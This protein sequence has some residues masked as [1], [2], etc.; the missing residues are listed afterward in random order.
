MAII[1]GIP[2]FQ[3][4]PYKWKFQWEMFHCHGWLPESMHEWDGGANC[5]RLAKARKN[6]WVPRSIKSLIL[7]WVVEGANVWA[8]I[9]TNYQIDNQ[10]GGD[11]TQ[12]QKKTTLKRTKPSILKA[13][14]TTPPQSWNN[15]PLG[16]KHCTTILVF[17]WQLAPVVQKVQ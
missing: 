6:L 9:V 8:T 11:S 7:V 16:S 17:G 1:G 3:T 13:Q 14:V 12:L 5:R 15:F 2:H 4:Y 10:E